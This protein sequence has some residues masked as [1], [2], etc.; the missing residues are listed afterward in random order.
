[1]R[2]GFHFPDD[3]DVWQRLRWDL[4][5]H[6]RSAHFI[7]G[8]ARLAD[9]TSLE[10]ARAAGSDARGAA[11]HRVREQQQRLG[12]RHRAAARRPARLLPAG[13]VRTLRRGRPALRH[14]LPERGVAAAHAGAVARER[15]IAVRTALG[16]TPRQIVTQLLAESL[17]LSVFGAAAGLARRP[18]RA[19]GDHRRHAGR[20][21]AP[22]G[23]GDQRSRPGAG[24]RPR[25]RDDDR[26][27]PGA[28]TDPGAEARRRRSAVGRTRQLARQRGAPIRG[29][30]S[31]KSRWRARCSSALSFSS[32]RSDR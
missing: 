16:A 19:A 25:R 3:V 4:T 10:Q 17:I 9:G 1:M 15:E 26:L 32:A 22:G 5:Q 7:E 6:S 23:G 27:R 20:G 21:A 13:A 11:R 12:I 30:S 28:G 18:G 24:A 31:R 8:V 14:R 2:A 29:S